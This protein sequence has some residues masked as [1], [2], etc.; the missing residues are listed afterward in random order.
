MPK[1]NQTL[2]IL[3]GIP[4]SGKSTWAKDFCKYNAGWVRVSRDDFRL[5]L[6]Q[7][8]MCEPKIEDLITTLVDET[9]KQAL[10]KKENVIVD[11]TNVKASY[12]QRF[13]DNFQN[14]AD[15]KFRIFDISVGKAIERD[16][17]R[18]A[19]VGEAVIRK[20]YKDYQVLI[21]SFPL[22]DLK[23]T[24]HRNQ[25]KPNENGNAIIVDIDGTLTFMSDRDPYDYGKVYKD[26]VNPLV[27]DIVKAHKAKGHKVILLTG[28]DG[29]ALS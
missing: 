26:E 7:A 6:K 23:R 13:I 28:R 10:F 27:V 11:A 12:I 29:E 3:I 5:M 18:E 25:L 16:K 19:T 4:G 14:S 9:I 15:I 8:Q 1:D 20:M 17:N 24:S 2:Q 22:Q 21:D